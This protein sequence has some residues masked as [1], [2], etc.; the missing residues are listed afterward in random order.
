M[1]NQNRPHR[2]YNYITVAQGDVQ[3]DTLSNSTGSNRYT[4]KTTV[5]PEERKPRLA[6]HTDSTS[7][8]VFLIP[9]ELHMKRLAPPGCSRMQDHHN[10]IKTGFY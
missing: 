7:D 5:V 6:T 10:E 2:T 1:I 8:Q 4:E 9:M 3:S